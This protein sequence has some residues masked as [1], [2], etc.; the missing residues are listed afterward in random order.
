MSSLTYFGGND[1]GK[2]PIGGDR[3]PRFK[4]KKGETYRIS[5]AW[6]PLDANDN[7]DLSA[8]KPRFIGGKRVYIQGAGYVLYKPEMASMTAEQPKVNVSTIIVVWPCDPAGNVDQ[9]R[10]IKGDYKVSSWTF[11][12]ARY[13]VLEN[14]FLRWPAGDHDVSALCE[15]EQYQKMTFSPERSSLLK[16]ILSS[17]KDK[18]KALAADLTAKIKEMEANIATEFARDLS[19][20]EIRLKMG[21]ATAGGAAPISA[22]STGVAANV[23]DMLGNILDD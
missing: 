11:G 18:M 15:D 13:K 6:W 20:D 22:A 5:F 9:D 23:D 14:N 10:L 2:A 4:G 12:E 3:F 16:Q 19:L 8:K 7:F 1:E 21:K 17:D